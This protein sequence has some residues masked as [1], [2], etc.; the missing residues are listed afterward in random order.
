MAADLVQ[1][2]TTGH[3]KIERYTL[4]KISVAMG[5]RGLEVPQQKG[6][7]RRFCE[8]IKEYV[9]KNCPDHC[10]ALIEG[11]KIGIVEDFEDNEES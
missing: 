2:G 4:A 6:T 11:A 8:I 1:K 9:E 10:L 7:K 5:E 3:L